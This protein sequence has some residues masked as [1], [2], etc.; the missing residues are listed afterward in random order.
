[1]LWFSIILA[2]LAVGVLAEFAR[3]YGGTKAALTV[4]TVATGAALAIWWPH[5]GDDEALWMF[6]TFCF[7]FNMTNLLPPLRRLAT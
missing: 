2:G 3:A 6:L 5:R 1:M 7:A 4:T